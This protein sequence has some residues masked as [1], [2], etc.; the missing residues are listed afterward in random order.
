[1]VL[2]V[3]EKSHGRAAASEKTKDTLSPKRLAKSARVCG[4]EESTTRRQHGGEAMTRLIASLEPAPNVGSNSI[5][6][7]CE[8]GSPRF[9]PIAR[10]YQQ[11]T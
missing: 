2:V 9:A 5:G 10:H 8:D 1:M 6:K 4:L 11:V 7:R 3:G